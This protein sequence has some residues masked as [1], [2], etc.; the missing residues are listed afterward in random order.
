MIYVN[1][2]KVSPREMQ[3]YIGDESCSFHTG[4]EK[5][6]HEFATF[7]GQTLKHEHAFIIYM[8]K[9]QSPPD[10]AG[11]DRFIATLYDLPA[12]ARFMLYVNLLELVDGPQGEDMGFWA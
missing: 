12:T 10:W 5:G 7:M 1:V 11:M 8:M 4:I 6:E 9:R 3:V 2:R